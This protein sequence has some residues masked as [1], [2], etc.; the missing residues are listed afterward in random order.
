MANPSGHYAF[1]DSEI[2]AQRLAIVAAVFA[3]TT[4]ALLESLALEP[5]RVLDLGCG[6]GYTTELL[7]HCY[8]DAEIVAIDSSEAFAHAAGARVHRA[9]VR[10][11]DVT[12]ALPGAFDL[13]YSRFLLSHLPAVER[14]IAHWCDSLAPG[15]YLVLEEP[16]RITATDPLFARYEEIVSA[17]VAN[18]GA[19]MYAGQQM[20][21]TP[22]PPGTTRVVDDVVDPHVR[23]GDAAE[24]FWRNACAW[25]SSAEGVVTAAE[26]D[27]IVDALRARVDD[28]SFDA[29]QWSLRRLVL[30]RD[31][32]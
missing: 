5:R 29:V 17:V 32:D 8:P 11:A 14:A 18:S 21:T 23:T 6:P 13:V 30:R 7:A 26:I 15:G 24:M 1:G 3:P 19:D 12:A 10:V 16:E 4:R 2:A 28:P 9:T 25:G 27:E 22:T 31:A 20:A